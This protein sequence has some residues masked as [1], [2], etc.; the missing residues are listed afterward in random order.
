VPVKS[1]IIVSPVP[2]RERILSCLFLVLLVWLGNFFESTK[3]SLYVDD[4][5]FLGRAL[6]VT[7]W[8]ENF[9]ANVGAYSDG[10]PIQFGLIDLTGQI[11]SA[12]RSF[13]PAYV[14]LFGLTAASIV[15]T[16]WALTYRFSNTVALIAAAVLALSPL[17]SVRAFLNG[18]ASPAALLFL[19]LAGVLHVTGRRI[20]SYAVS[21]LIL[22]S[23]EL[24]FPAFVLLPALLAP[25]RSRRDVYRLIGH[26]LICTALLIGYTVFKDH[27]GGNRLQAALAGHSAVDLGLGIVKTT[28]RSLVFGLWGSVDLPLWLNRITASADTIVWGFLAFAAFACLLHRLPRPA[29]GD[30]AYTAQSVAILLFLSLSGY[31][32]VYFASPD[33]AETVL[34]RNSRFHS[35]ASL[36]LSVLTGLA[37]VWLMAAARGAFLRSA[38]V[39]LSAAY[40]ALIFAF[41]VSHQN[42]FAGETE[43][44]RLLVAQLVMDHPKMDPQATFIVVRPG[45]DWR[46]LSS[47]E[48]ADN[49]SFYYL[50]P[51]LFDFGG[52]GRRVGPAIRMVRGDDWPQ[53]LTVGEGDAI[54]WPSWMWPPRPE[55]IGNIWAYEQAA[56]GRLTP[57][58]GPI[59]VGGRNILHDGPDVPEGAVDLRKAKRLPLF[60]VFLGPQAAIVNA[61]LGADRATPANGGGRTD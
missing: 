55:H 18:I 39:G 3:F 59:M 45:G 27:Y 9:V 57:V 22:L 54:N 16:W 46:Q 7:N 32:L 10:R 42:E 12:T 44:Q 4:L 13:G 33:G 29:A 36:P 56:D 14:F 41:S 6:Q 49:H 53:L 19:M 26:A 23:Y 43:R 58:S 1:G 37:L 2:P 15:A 30:R 60:D 24:A 52:N 40:L 11:I 47:I 35:V 38:A 61:A 31:V 50:L 48:S 17:V 25:L 34:D 28:F 51:D 8:F 21:V 5:S 20:A